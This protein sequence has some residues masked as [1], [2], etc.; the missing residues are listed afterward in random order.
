MAGDVTAGV[1]SQFSKAGRLGSA[2]NQDVLADSLGDL[3]TKI[4]APNYQQER[5]NMQNVLFQAPA[6]SEADYL[7]INKLRS[8]GAEREAL[9]Q[10]ILADAM[11]R[12]QYQQMLPYEKLRN[13][14]AA[15]GGSYGQTST[16]IQPLTRNVGAGLL[17]GALGGAELAGM[18][19]GLGGGMGAGIGAILGGLL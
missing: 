3:A 6:L 15:T 14:Q 4:Y 7:D 5:A 17:G 2:A 19:P 11:N 9:Q 10:N 13:Y 16:Q 12:F 1:Q 8:I 18:I